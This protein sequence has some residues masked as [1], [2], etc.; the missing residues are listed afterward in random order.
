LTLDL[1]ELAG[2]SV[3]MQ[4]Y[5]PANGQYTDIA[6]SNFESRGAQTVTIRPI[7]NNS[8]GFSDWVLILKA[9]QARD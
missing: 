4:W 7:A 5:D 2:P 6:T 1:R 8:S 3:S 9:T